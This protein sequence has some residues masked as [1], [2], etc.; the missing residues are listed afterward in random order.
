[1]TSAHLHLPLWH[2]DWLIC[3]SQPNPVPT[4]LFFNLFLILSQ[5]ESSQINYF[6]RSGSWVEEQAL[7]QDL[8]RLS[9]DLF[10]SFIGRDR[11]KGK[12]RQFQFLGDKVLYKIAKLHH[13][14]RWTGR[15]SVRR[16]R[17][18][19]E[20]GDEAIQRRPMMARRGMG[21]KG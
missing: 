4:P 2:G 18:A 9:A 11:L 14:Q 3:E 17:W 7:P 1:M 19:A 20:G 8:R 12:H 21:Q 5:V 6:P 13:V 15:G 10:G 16:D